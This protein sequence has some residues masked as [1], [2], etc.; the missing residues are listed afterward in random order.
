MTEITIDGVEYDLESLS[1]NAK[2]QLASLQAC[3]NKIRQLQTELTM[4]QTA[5]TAYGMAL[6]GEL[7]GNGTAPTLESNNPEPEDTH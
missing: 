4:V 5:K 6:K 7:P 3:D 1:E 2:G